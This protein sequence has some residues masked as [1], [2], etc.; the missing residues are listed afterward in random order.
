MKEQ[1]ACTLQA[2]ARSAR[3][4]PRG[5]LDTDTNDDHADVLNPT[6]SFSIF[7]IQ[8]SILLIANSLPDLFAFG[9]IRLRKNY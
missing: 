1:R 2:R 4:H 9:K 5:C 3:A 6:Y 8:I 7:I